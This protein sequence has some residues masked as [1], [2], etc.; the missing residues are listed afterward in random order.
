[1]EVEE[2]TAKWKSEYKAKTYYF[3]SSICKQQFERNPEKFV[4]PA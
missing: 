4:K 1:M 2:G 3:C